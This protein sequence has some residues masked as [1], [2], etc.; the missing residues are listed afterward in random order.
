MNYKM[1]TENELFKQNDDIIISI[2]KV[3]K[4]LLESP[5][6]DSSIEIR[7]KFISKL[8]ETYQKSHPFSSKMILPI[9]N[10]IEHFKII[11]LQINS[12]LDFF[13]D[14]IIESHLKHEKITKLILKEIYFDILVLFDLHFEENKKLFEQ[15]F[16]EEF[17]NNLR[18]D[19]K[20]NDLRIKILKYLKVIFVNGLKNESYSEL[21]LLTMKKNQKK[22]SMKKN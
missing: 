14:I 22:R 11:N 10:N 13:F 8:K 12:V 20:K 16:K 7:S 3:L 18:I 4:F 17:K 5:L 15:H 1:K 21:L 19:W 9:P 6:N 2:H